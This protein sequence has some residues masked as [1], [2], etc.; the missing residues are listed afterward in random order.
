MDTNTALKISNIVI[1]KGF[2]TL[3]ATIL[4]SL[5]GAFIS[6]YLARK[7]FQKEHQLLQ[8]QLEYQKEQFNIEQ[9]M[10]I[11]LLK[12]EYL[13]KDNKEK[14]L[15][16]EETYE[17]LSAI[18]SKCSITSSFISTEI[19]SLDSFHKFY[20]DEIVNRIN[21]IQMNVGLYFPNLKKQ[22]DDIASQANLFWGYQQQYLRQ[23]TNGNHNQ[24]DLGKVI[25]AAN[26]ISSL[27]S[28]MQYALKTEFEEIFKSNK[29]LER[30]I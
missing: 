26:R 23:Q 21:K 25:E 1:D 14:R 19:D 29:S 16:I 20:M 7:N 22:I 3:I 8:Q 30:N 12:L 28:S 6:I 13:A 17:L 11:K 15:H 5:I 2:A 18:K 10:K 27:A 9:N 24:D 4:G